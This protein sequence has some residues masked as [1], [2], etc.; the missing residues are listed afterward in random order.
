M[1]SLLFSKKRIKALNGYKYRH[2]VTICVY[3][4]EYDVLGLFWFRGSRVDIDAVYNWTCVCVCTY[5]CTYI[6]HVCFP[7]VVLFEVN[8]MTYLRYNKE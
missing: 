5:T 7:H 8:N 4:G 6:L 2:L 3:G 1:K